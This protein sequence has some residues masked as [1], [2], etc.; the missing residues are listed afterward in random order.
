MTWK[1]AK[2]EYNDSKSCD[3]WRIDVLTICDNRVNVLIDD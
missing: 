2:N 1:F 3:F